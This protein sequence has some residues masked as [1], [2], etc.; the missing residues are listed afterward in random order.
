MPPPAPPPPL[1][2]AMPACDGPSE[3]ASPVT[4]R[5]ASIV[6]GVG[7]RGRGGSDRGEEDGPPAEPACWAPGTPSD[8]Q[9]PARKRARARAPHACTPAHHCISAQ[10]SPSPPPPPLAPPPWEPI[11]ICIP[12][13]PPPWEPW[14]PS[15]VT[16]PNRAPAL[17]C[18][19]ARAARRHARHAAPPRG[20]TSDNESL[21]A[22]G[23]SWRSAT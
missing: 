2:C 21:A 15:P 13:S 17:H 11:G 1:R 18:A 4:A 8:P 16:Q 14:E 19:R 9:T 12:P 23:T 10:V 6:R 20:R 22:S 7:S 5:G 3:N